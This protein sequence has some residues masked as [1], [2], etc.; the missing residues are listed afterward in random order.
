MLPNLYELRKVV[1]CCVH[2]SIVF[3]AHIDV[4]FER[5]YFSVSK[6]VPDVALGFPCQFSFQLLQ[7]STSQKM[8]TD[9]V[10]DSIRQSLEAY[11]N[12]TQGGFATR[13]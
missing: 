7:A 5:K 12:T 8:I 11:M 4:D 2:R 13:F 3:Y 6:T 9:T 10:G 1:L